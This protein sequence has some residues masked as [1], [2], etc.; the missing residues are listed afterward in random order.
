LAS[1][2][3]SKKTLAAT[4]GKGTPTEDSYGNG[5][6]GVEYEKK[7]TPP[8]APVSYVAPRCASEILY[9]EPSRRRFSI[10]IMLRIDSDLGLDLL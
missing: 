8:A 3:Y 2:T 5:F 10:M 6:D 7:I 9:Q 1:T 4:S